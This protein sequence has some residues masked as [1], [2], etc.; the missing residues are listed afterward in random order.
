LARESASRR[1]VLTGGPGAGKSVLGREIAGRFADR[2]VLVPESATHVYTTL[3]T[4]W[5]RLS[6]EARRDVQRRIYHNQVEQ[7][8]RIAAADPGQVLLLDRGTIDG[9]AY[10]PEGPDDY[11]RD[12][13]T[14]HALELARYDTVIWL[15][16]AA[17]LGIY[18]GDTSN[19]VRFED[20]DAAVEAGKA[21]LRLWGPHP[22]LRHV[23]AFVSL[24]DKFAAVCELLPS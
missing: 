14:T 21:L 5:D 16:T 10:W 18:D 24:E 13:G 22:N 7:E 9:A 11:W 6:I 2:F 15:E 8:S 12:L 4:R 23:G 19:D 17:A 3:G 1:I 20:A